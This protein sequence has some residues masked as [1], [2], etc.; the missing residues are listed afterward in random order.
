MLRVV[1]IRS[2]GWLMTKSYK[3]LADEN[4]VLYAQLENCTMLMGKATTD[5]DFKLH[6]EYYFAK[7]NIKQ[8]IENNLELIEKIWETPIITIDQKSGKKKMFFEER[9][10]QTYLNNKEL[11]CKVIARKTNNTIAVVEDVLTRYLIT[12]QKEL[13]SA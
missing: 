7:M 2:I 3:Q 13:T 5:G 9:I 1:I 6:M 10:I 8:L 11:N 12:K 4:K